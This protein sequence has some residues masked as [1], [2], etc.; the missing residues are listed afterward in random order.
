MAEMLVYDNC[1][2]SVGEWIMFDDENVSMVT[3]EDIL[4]LSGGG[5][6]FIYK[7]QLSNAVDLCCCNTSLPV[8]LVLLCDVC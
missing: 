2:V 4:K 1:N 6:L 3:S 5:I 7:Y 8:D